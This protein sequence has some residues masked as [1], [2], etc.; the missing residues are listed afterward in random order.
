[1]NSSAT[2]FAISRSYVASEGIMSAATTRTRYPHSRRA[3]ASLTRRGSAARFAE[4]TRQTVARFTLHL[5]LLCEAVQK[6]DAVYSQPSMRRVGF[7]LPLSIRRCHAIAQ[8]VLFLSE[9]DR[10][11][12]DPQPVARLFPAGQN[13][14]DSK[15]R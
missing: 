1:M 9:V 6:A 10:Y 2:C 12:R 13:A 14:L 7:A 5:H 3:E 8:M 11:R 15:C 4:V